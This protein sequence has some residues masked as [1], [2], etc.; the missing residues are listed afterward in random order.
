MLGPIAHFLA[1]HAS[2]KF[3]CVDAEVNG[4]NRK[5]QDGSPSP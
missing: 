2:E 4:E 3:R 5:V 1:T